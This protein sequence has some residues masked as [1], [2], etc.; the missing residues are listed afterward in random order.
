M[1]IAGRFL[2][3]VCI[4]CNGQ[5]T[6]FDWDE[7][8]EL[9]PVF[10]DAIQH[11]VFTRCE[12]LGL[13]LYKHMAEINVIILSKRPFDVIM[14]FQSCY[15]LAG[16]SILVRRLH[17]CTHTTS[18]TRVKPDPEHSTAHADHG[19]SRILWAIHFYVSEIGLRCTTCY[20]ACRGQ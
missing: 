17:T 10:D 7:Y 13:G 20:Y 1:K 4:K 16:F 19:G 5:H 3:F 18:T 12:M 15:V 14:P 8:P 2:D 6:V 11:I 9:V